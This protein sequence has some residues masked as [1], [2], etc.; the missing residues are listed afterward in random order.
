MT[1]IPNGMRSDK[2]PT[3]RDRLV[4][5]TVGEDEKPTSAYVTRYMEESFTKLG[6]MAEIHQAYP[7]VKFMGKVLGKLRLLRRYLTSPRKILIVPANSIAEYLLFPYG[8]FHEVV[9]VS[10]DCW[11]DRYDE[12]ERYFLRHKIKLA[13]I[14]AR[15]SAEEM[16]RRLPHM[17]VVWMPEA[18][19]PLDYDPSKKLTDR[20]TDVLEL[21]RKYDR[22]HSQ[23]AASLRDSGRSHLYEVTKGSMI[24]PDG[25]QHLI[26]GMANAKVSVCFPGSW[27]HPYAAGVETMTH[28]YLQTFA[29][30]C[31]PIGH[32][33]PEMLDLFGYNP[34]IE[35]DL[36]N[37]AVQLDEILSNIGDYQDL[38]DRNYDAVIEF[39]SW[40]V[41]ARQVIEHI[42]GFF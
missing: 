20:P 17:T 13:F 21:G 30:K 19:D 34:V 22:F 29:S 31:L 28:R 18:T 41:R 39:G 15:K 7:I 38:V 36:D 24:F 37:A 1:A 27:T 12:W 16:Q 3:V 2:I 23:T 25:K 10:F 35:A 14:S 42:E 5:V 9:P 11:P 8:C 26:D 33:P 40:D 6:V 32:A 4:F